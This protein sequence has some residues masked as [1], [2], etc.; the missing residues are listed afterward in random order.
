[1]IIG[2]PYPMYERKK[3]PKLKEI[4]KYFIIRPENG[5]NNLEDLE[6]DTSIFNL[7]KSFFKRKKKYE[8]VYS[9]NLF[10][11]NSENER[12]FEVNMVGFTIL[13]EKPKNLINLMNQR[14]AKALIQ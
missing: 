2:K 8:F 3:G 12:S 11:S 14:E 10:K 9:R 6:K 7:W 5:G 1:M 13:K 4:F